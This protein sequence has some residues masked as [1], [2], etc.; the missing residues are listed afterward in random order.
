MKYTS[1]EAYTTIV[2]NGLLFKRRMEVYKLIAEH[3][4]ISAND[5]YRLVKKE[6]GTKGNISG[7]ASRFG[8]LEEMG[9][10]EAVGTNTDEVSG[11]ACYQYAITNNLPRLEKK[12]T[13]KEIIARLKKEIELL[14]RRI[15]Y[16]K[17]KYE[18]KNQDLFD[19]YA[20]LED[21]LSIE[22]V[23]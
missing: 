1:L 23:G 21:D 5:L 15:R 12:E 18:T 4:P 8:E 17:N 20:D 3:G 6:T 19:D 22:G 13:S 11:K 2:T 10:I 9:C 14:K 7:W 16:L